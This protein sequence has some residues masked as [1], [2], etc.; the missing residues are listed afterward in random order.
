MSALERGAGSIPS[1][2]AVRAPAPKQ[3][4]KVREKVLKKGT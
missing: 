4:H 1:G 2:M 3:R